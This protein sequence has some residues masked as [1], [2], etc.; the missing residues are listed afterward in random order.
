MRL[1]LK[2]TYLL[3]SGRS[4]K[5]GDSKHCHLS[6]Y[7]F[8]LDLQM[9]TAIVRNKLAEQIDR[10]ISPTRFGFRKDPRTTHALSIAG[11]L[12]GMSEQTGDNLVQD[13]L[14]GINVLHS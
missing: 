10:H 3:R 12:Q 7:F 9:F 2:I 8:D 4:Y 5:K 13:C 6:F 14:I 11:L 1:G